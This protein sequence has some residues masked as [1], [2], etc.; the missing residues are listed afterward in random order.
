MFYYKCSIINVFIAKKVNSQKF[1]SLDNK[2]Y[3]DMHSGFLLL[4]SYFYTLSVLNL[5]SSLRMQL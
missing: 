3:F 2:V 1:H 5:A 4:R